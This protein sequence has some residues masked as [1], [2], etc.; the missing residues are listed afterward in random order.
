MGRTSAGLFPVTE[1]EPLSL[2][3]QTRQVD[4]AAELIPRRVVVHGG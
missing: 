4:S 3:V 2:G 1:N